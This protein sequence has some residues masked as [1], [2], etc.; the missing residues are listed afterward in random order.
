MSRSLAELLTSYAL[1]TK[2]MT[3]QYII[4]A[5]SSCAIL[6][7]GTSSTEGQWPTRK[8]RCGKHSTRMWTRMDRSEILLWMSL[9][10][11]ITVIIAMMRMRTTR[12]KM[13]PT[14]LARFWHVWTWSTT[15]WLR[16]K[17]LTNKARGQAARETRRRNRGSRTVARKRIRSTRQKRKSTARRPGNTKG[18]KGELQGDSTRPLRRSA[19]LQERQPNS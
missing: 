13:V 9:I 3:M 12:I 14:A 11:R 15:A 16:L 1:P 7:R 10:P 2:S 4:T 17:E 8:M 19:R 6:R 5:R 18:A